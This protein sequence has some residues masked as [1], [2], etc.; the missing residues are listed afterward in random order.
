M[1]DRG[2]KFIVEALEKNTVLRELELQSNS[3][4]LV[5]CRCVHLVAWLVS[6]GNGFSSTL[7]CHAP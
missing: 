4:G 3:I 2:V 7:V 5:G 6:F 1:G